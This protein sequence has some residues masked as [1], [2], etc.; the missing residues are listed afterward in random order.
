MSITQKLFVKLPGSTQMN[1]ANSLLNYNILYRL[2]MFRMFF[3]TLTAFGAE[4]HGDCQQP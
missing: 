3:R 1:I 4:R 2:P